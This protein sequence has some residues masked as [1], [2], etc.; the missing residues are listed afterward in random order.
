MGATAPNPPPAI[1]PGLRY[2]QPPISDR[3]EQRVSWLFLM[4]SPQN[5]FLLIT[6]NLESRLGQNA[7]QI[8]DKSSVFFLFSLRQI[9][10]KGKGRM[11][12]PI[13]IP[14]IRIRPALTLP[15]SYPAFMP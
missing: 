4:K 15:Y 7:R 6:L 2:A 14:L 3:R 9:L 1:H 13:I 5:Y 11:N 10:P 8:T 12:L